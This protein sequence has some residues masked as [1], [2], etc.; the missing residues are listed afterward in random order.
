MGHT[1]GMD[2]EHWG[3][4]KVVLSPAL[5]KRIKVRRYGKIGGMH[6]WTVDGEVV[7]NHVYQ[8]FTAGGN[9]GRYPYV[10]A[11]EIW[12]EKTFTPGDAA[13]VIA[14]EYAEWK[15]MRHSRQSYDV[16][17]D[18]ANDVE[19]GIRAAK[20]AGLVVPANFTEAVEVAKKACAADG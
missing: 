3:P 18:H 19:K 10:P 17:H 6:V 11:N 7:R 8:D 15:R 14:H 20:V 13:G 2:R 1:L 16:A 9:P 12:I 4:G 5:M